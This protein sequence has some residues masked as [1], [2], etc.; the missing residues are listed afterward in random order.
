LAFQK[1]RLATARFFHFAVGDFSDFQ[2][3]GDRPAMRISSP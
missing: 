3:G 2:F 1:Q